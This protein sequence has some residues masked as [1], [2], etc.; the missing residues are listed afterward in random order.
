MTFDEIST[1]LF[2]LEYE[3][4]S[5]AAE[6]MYISQGTAS[7]RIKSLEK[8]LNFELFIRNKGQKKLELTELGRRF[9]P[10]A[11]QISA[12]WQDALQL[13]NSHIYEMV[14]IAGIDVINVFTLSQFYNDFVNNNSDIFLKINTHHSSRIHDLIDKHLIDIGFVFNQKNY[15]TISSTPLYEEEMVIIAQKNSRYNE[16]TRL[17]ELSIS[18]E[19][20]VRWGTD[21]ELWHNRH[22]ESNIP[23]KITVG[24]GSMQ[25]AYITDENTW[26][27][28]PKSIALSL[29][30]NNPNMKYFRLE[31][32]PPNCVCY[33]L[34]NK[35]N[36]I[37]KKISID[38]LLFELQDH[39]INN[40]AITVLKEF[41]MH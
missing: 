33:L 35:H 9:V 11:Q 1:F 12:L 37:A 7:N 39:L 30:R 18:N 5:K 29:I 14:K 2:A 26:A 8:E 10:T 4:L 19:V 20:Y 17:D 41:A 21:F 22:F 31:K 23:K 38:K 13:K 28:T 25:G 6:I 16:N 32:N 15:E 34:I 40:E 27:F 3:S 36:K 24:T